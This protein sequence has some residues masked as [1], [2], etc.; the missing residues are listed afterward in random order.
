MG[1]SFCRECQGKLSCH[2]RYASIYA[3]SDKYPSMLAQGL[4]SGKKGKTKGLN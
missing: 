4:D 1:T 2:P 3:L